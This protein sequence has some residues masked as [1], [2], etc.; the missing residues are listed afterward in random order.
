MSGSQNE[1]VYRILV[2]VRKV[3]TVI[4]KQGS[5]IKSLRDETGAKIKIADPAPGSE[6]RVVIVSGADDP[7]ASFSAA[8]EALFRVHQRVYESEMTEEG[9]NTTTTRMLVD[10]SQA[11]CLIG[12]GGEIIKMIREGSG[13]HVRILPPEEVP[14]CA[15]PTDRVVQMVGDPTSLRSCLQMVSKQLRENPPKDR[16]MQHS[17]GNGGNRVG[18][19]AGFPGQ[20]AGFQNFGFQQNGMGLGGLGM[21][22]GLGMGMAGLGGG[23]GLGTNGNLGMNGAQAQVAGPQISSQM[24]VSS[25]LVG[26][27][28]GRSGSNIQLIRHHSGAKIKVHDQQPGQTERVV[29]ITGAAEQVTTAQQLVQTFIAQGT[30]AATTGTSPPQSM[31][32]DE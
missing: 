11:G 32:M 19:M 30:P 4:G 2:N 10:G 3:G 5:I 20:M 15:L 7:T 31:G 24:S 8:Q 26:N 23:M 12:K 6:E 21:Q 17:S 29:E 1:A 13:A 25:A 27:I 14:P 16:P 28:I 18:Q 9:S 22:G